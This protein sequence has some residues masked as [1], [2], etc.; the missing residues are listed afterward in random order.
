MDFCASYE[1]IPLSEICSGEC[2]G[3]ATLDLPPVTAVAS[4][5]AE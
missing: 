2:D 1:E 5:D 4:A 3:E